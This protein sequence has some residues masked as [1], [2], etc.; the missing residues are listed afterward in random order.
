[1]PCIRC[2]TGKKFD[3]PRL[4]FQFLSLITHEL[5]ILRDCI[6]IVY[7]Y[8]RQTT[9]SKMIFHIVKEFIF[10]NHNIPG[11]HIKTYIC[12]VFKFLDSEFP[13]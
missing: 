2:T 7:Q 5:H 6:N 12:V 11:L 13:N 1:M 4:Y 3:E 9:K 8:S 10:V